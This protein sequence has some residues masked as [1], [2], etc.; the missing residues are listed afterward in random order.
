[1]RAKKSIFWYP[2]GKKIRL[3]HWKKKILLVWLLPSFSSE[4][5]LLARKINFFPPS[6]VLYYFLLAGHKVKFKAP[7][8]AKKS[9]FW[10]PSGKKF[11]CNIGKKFIL[12]VW[13]LPSFSSDIKLLARKINFFLPSCVLYYFLLAGHKVNFK[14]PCG[15][16]K[17]TFWPSR[18]TEN[19]M[20]LGKKIYFTRVI[21][22]LVFLGYQTS[23]SQNKLFLPS[24]VIYHYNHKI[25]FVWD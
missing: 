25:N 15:A 23:R 20:Q 6:C 22:D 16:N 7:C 19:R 3:Q 1:M 11:D 14:A 13:M 5:K 4:I 8:R 2:S 24:C 17:S 9:I 18:G 12:L 10:Y 21:V